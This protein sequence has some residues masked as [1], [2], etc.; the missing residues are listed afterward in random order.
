[1]V[2]LTTSLPIS[3]TSCLMTSAS[4]AL[5]VVALDSCLTLKSARISRF[6]SFILVMIH[7]PA[8]ST[9]PLHKIR[10]VMPANIV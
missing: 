3:K 7:M 1:M 5:T 10:S 2:P 8:P 9:V 4:K 6:I